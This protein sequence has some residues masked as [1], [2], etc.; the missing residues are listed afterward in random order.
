[1]PETLWVVSRKRHLWGALKNNSGVFDDHYTANALGLKLEGLHREP[2]YIFRVSVELET[3][4]ST[5]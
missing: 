4:G 5:Q 2:F 1:M 3:D